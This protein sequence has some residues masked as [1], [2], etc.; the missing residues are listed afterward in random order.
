MTIQLLFVCLGNICRSPAAEGTMN[1]LIQQA[2]WGDRF[3]C[4]SAGT[5]RYHI[6]DSPDRRMTL[7][8]QKREI[9]LEGKARQF[10]GQDFDQF[11]LILAM[12]RQNYRDI[13]ALASTELQRQKVH[14][15]CDFCTQYTDQDVPD[16]YYGGADGFVYVLDLLADACAGLLQQLSANLDSPD[17]GAR[18]GGARL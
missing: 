8:A 3:G 4:D 9:F 18:L 6:G 15:I 10:R 7:T 14:L 1:H 13:L 2:G 5:S 11:D 17:G 16:P 12:D